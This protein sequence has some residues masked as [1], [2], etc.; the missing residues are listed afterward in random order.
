MYCTGTHINTFMLCCINIYLFSHKNWIMNTESGIH[1]AHRSRIISN[2]YIPSF[3]FPF[4]F[5]FYFHFSFK[6]NSL[7]NFALLLKTYFHTFVPCLLPFANLRN[8]PFAL[9]SLLL[10]FYFVE[11]CVREMDQAKRLFFFYSLGIS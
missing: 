9:L 2:T 7:M 3:Y 6:F 5:S 8:F 1:N 10:F 4:L 11:G